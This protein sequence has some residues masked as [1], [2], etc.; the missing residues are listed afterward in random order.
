MNEE[1]IYADKGLRRRSAFLAIVLVAVGWWILKLSQDYL[2]DLVTLVENDPKEA[3]NK[4]TVLGCIFRRWVSGNN[5]LPFVVRNQNYQ[6]RSVPPARH[7][8]S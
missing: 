7:E 8:G 5:W 4:L 3:R 6:Y 2:N 1:I